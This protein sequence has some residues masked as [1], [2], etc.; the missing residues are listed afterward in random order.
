VSGVAAPA[1][2]PRAA[3]RRATAW[4]RVADRLAPWLRLAAFVGLA[5]LGSAYWASF[6]ADA[7]SGR[8]AGVLAI[9]TVFAALL[10][11]LG[12]L[13]LPRGAA[14]ALA[15][16]AALV[17]LAMGM[18]AIGLDASLL[19]PARWDD[20]GGLVQR[21]LDGLSTVSWPYDGPD[22]FVRLTIL[23]AIPPVL[24]LAAA[25]AFWPVRRQPGLDSVALALLI[26]FYT[27]AITDQQFGGELGLGVLLL[28]LVAAWLW[29]P[30]LGRR[31]ALAGA[32]AIAAAG[33]LA[34]PVAAA[35]DV[36]QPWFD[37]ASW[38]IGSH[39]KSS[40]TFEWDHRYGAISWPR[41]GRTLLAVRSKEPHYWKAETLDHF[42][43]LRWSHMRDRTPLAAELP[44]RYV[45]SWAAEISVTVRDLRSDL[46]V[47]AGTMLE[48]RGDLGDRITSGD[49]TVRLID[50]PLQT[51]DSY[52]VRAYVPDPSAGAMQA[53]PDL[54]GD[55]LRKYV[56]FAL[57][58]EGETALNT[59]PAHERTHF[60][61]EDQ[62]SMPFRGESYQPIQR[63]DVLKIRRSPYRRTY[64][65]A[66]RLAAGQATT[67]DVVR[68]TER[69]LQRTLTYSERVPTRPYPL[70]GFLFE[71]KIGYC[72]QFSGAMAL[73]LR[74]NGIPARVAAGF[75][76]G[77]YDS[78]TKEFRVR[79]LDA[80]SWVEVYFEGIGWVPFDPTPTAAPAAAQSTSATS[81]SAARGGNDR[82]TAD[83]AAQSSTYASS[84]AGNGG[85]GSS[86]G[87][88]LLPVAA[89]LLAVLAV[90]AFWIYAV[91]DARRHR[92][93]APADPQLA[94]LRSALRR[95]GFDVPPRTT[96]SALEKRLRRFVGPASARY[97]VLL[98]ERRYGPAGAAPPGSSER[99]ALRR[100][101]A[102]AG[103]RLG[104]VRALLALP[105]RPTR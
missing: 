32:A 25:L 11:A 51:G 24:V 85:G 97:A 90:A 74:M 30:Q 58:T 5:G 29:L 98:R 43:G 4:D 73:M 55:Q 105:P 50:R 62:V 7:P 92:Q 19:E 31:G 100:E 15:A 37:Y 49:G 60:V 81:A 52:S 38:G 6:V 102:S 67:Y 33:V 93:A 45:P 79:D 95:M 78:T 82:S 99:A 23:L 42:D 44:T 88:W 103:G 34:L 16:L 3:L 28:V 1:P 48:T 40:T 54:W 69:W 91:V 76:P 26:A 18:V 77:I 104:W 65:L 87:W 80:H 89:L 17:A 53:A 63:D 20:F 75:A 83:S 71:D 59:P 72:Q 94:E 12:R 14:H 2:A 10:I 41:S 66:R 61:A 22:R 101:L 96:L 13:S 86:A 84:S 27:V 64:A 8:V 39:S 9:A 47:G 56:T 35:M 21:G 68:N 57:P 36:D 70:D 46:V